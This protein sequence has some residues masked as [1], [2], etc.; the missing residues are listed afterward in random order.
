MIKRLQYVMSYIMVKYI[1]LAYSLFAIPS[2]FCMEQVQATSQAQEAREALLSTLSGLAKLKTII[3]EHG[4]KETIDTL[5]IDAF[6]EKI[7]AF[8]A[9]YPMV[10]EV[11]KEAQETR[12]EKISKKVQL[13]ETITARPIENLHKSKE[14]ICAIAY[15][16]L[17][18]MLHSTITG[19]ITITKYVTTMVIILVIIALTKTVIAL[20]LPETPQEIGAMKLVNAGLQLMPALPTINKILKI[21]EQSLDYTVNLTALDAYKKLLDSLQPNQ[22]IFIKNYKLIQ[23]LIDPEILIHEMKLLKVLTNEQMCDLYT[24]LQA[25]GIALSSHFTTFK[26]MLRAEQQI[27][28]E[29]VN[30]FLIA[31]YNPLVLLHDDLFT[32]KLDA[33]QLNYLQKLVFGNVETLTPKTV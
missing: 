32:S 20:K 31:Q 17:G 27:I 6:P 19:D 29:P 23:A 18:F 26:Q 4:I 30:R 14:I 9:K 25:S 8:L 3:D 5:L 10:L 11:L 28:S 22:K 21:T 13:L 16:T 33:A 15:L 12:Q 1:I 24:Y 7:S 2:A